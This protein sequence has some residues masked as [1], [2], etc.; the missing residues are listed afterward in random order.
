MPRYPDEPGF[1]AGS[2]TSEE[3]AAR[4]IKIAPR[5]RTTVFNYVTSR[6][7]HGTTCDEA[8]MALNMRHQACSARLRELVLYNMIRIIGTRLTRSGRS[9]NVYVVNYKPRNPFNKDLTDV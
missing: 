9:A 1:V 5:Q 7:N 2:A 3:A 8:E 4:H 6:G